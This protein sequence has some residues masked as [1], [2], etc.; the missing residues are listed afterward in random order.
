MCKATIL[1]IMQG[2]HKPLSYVTISFSPSHYLIYSQ[3]CLIWTLYICFFIYGKQIDLPGCLFMCLLILWY[4]L[5]DKHITETNLLT[6]SNNIYLMFYAKEID[7]GTH[8][9]P[10]VWPIKTF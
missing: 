2:G 4:H 1:T 8:R 10:S 6:L 3:F 7:I 9:Y 5:D